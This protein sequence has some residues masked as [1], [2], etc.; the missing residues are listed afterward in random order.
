[1]TSRYHGSKMFGSQKRE[2]WQ[3]RRRRQRER[4]KSNNFIL[5]QNNNFAHAS[6]FSVHFFLPSLH[7]CDMKLR[8]TTQK[9]SLSFSKLRF[10]PFGFNPQK[11]RQ[12][13]VNLMKLNKIDEV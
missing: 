2:L 11:C 1:M 3:R 4:Q 7:E 10:G 13:L 5:G 9:V 12:Y 6:R 8:N